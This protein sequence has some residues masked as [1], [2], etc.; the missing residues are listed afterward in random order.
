[1]NIQKVALSS[2]VLWSRSVY[3]TLSL[4]KC[5]HI[6]HSSDYFYKLPSLK[7]FKDMKRIL[8]LLAVF[9]LLSIFSFAQRAPAAPPPASSGSAQPSEIIGIGVELKIDST[10]GYKSTVIN[11]LVA[12]GAAQAAGL[13]KGDVIMNVDN[14]STV[15]VALKNV[16][17]M[18]KGE[19]GTTVKLVVDRSGSILT[20]NIVR[21]KF[22]YASTNAASTTTT[23]TTAK[24]SYELEFEE[25]LNDDKTVT[26]VAEKKAETPAEE[27]KSPADFDMESSSSF[28]LD[29]SNFDWNNSTT[30]APASK[31][32]E[33]VTIGSQTWMAKNLDV[34]TF[35]NG[36]AIAE[37]RSDE[38]W[39]KAYDDKKP[40]WCYYNNDAA[41]GAKYGKL[42]NWWAI[43][44]TRGLAPSG[45][46]VPSTSDWNRLTSGLGTGA[47]KNMKS[48]SGW[49]ESGN[50]TNQSNFSALPG[51]FRETAPDSFG[52]IGSNGYWWSSSI[53]EIFGFELGAGLFLKNNSDEPQRDSYAAEGL[54]VRCI[55][56]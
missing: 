6:I 22:T 50:G 23:V 24:S 41:N 42:Y 5:P 49:N 36:D 48:S 47:A 56:D 19:E 53:N 38:D 15:N 20:Y 46:R 7:S 4:S 10:M 16:V 27:K 3:V 25:F 21:K 14:K 11:G 26:P 44:D 55:K 31:T 54:S 32:P 45:W 29:F 1:M 2:T 33:T 8:L 37:V 52:D 51:G 9:S 28:L 35:R 39:E 12:N 34:T 30:T 18:I 13:Q 17:D 40:A 43:V